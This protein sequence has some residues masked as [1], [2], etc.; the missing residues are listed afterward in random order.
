MDASELEAKRWLRKLREGNE[1]SQRALGELVGVDRR[2]ILNAESEGDDAGWPHG[3]TL[4]RMLQEL[5][6]VVDAPAPTETPLARLEEKV[7]ETLTGIADVLDLL[8]GA[9]GQSAVGAPTG[10][11]RP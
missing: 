11:P 10:T 5:G 2:T 7:D 8:R 4:L 3:F 9:P 6:A 1:L